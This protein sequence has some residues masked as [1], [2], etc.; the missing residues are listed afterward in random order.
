MAGIKDNAIRIMMTL[1][2]QFPAN[3]YGG[4]KELKEATQLDP[5]QL[6]D[7][8]EYLDNKGYIERQDFLGTAPYIFGMIRLNIHG[9]L[10][11]EQ[12]A[13]PADR[14]IEKVSPKIGAKTQ[15]A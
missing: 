7:A 15:P 14:P 11:L 8:V 3:G 12:S 13:E 9:K 2:D 10:F 6:N 5:N 4:G 1:R